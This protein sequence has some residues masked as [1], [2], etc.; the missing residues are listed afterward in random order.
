MPSFSE[1]LR[2]WFGYSRRERRSTFILLILIVAVAGV[3][4]VLPEHEII[5]EELTVETNTGTT[6]SMPFGENVTYTSFRQGQQVV[7]ARKPTELINLNTSDS[8]SLEALPGIGPVLSVRIIKYRNLLGGYA[9]VSQLKEVYGLSEETFNLISGRVIADSASVRKI[10]I[11]YSDFKELIRFPYFEREEVNAILKYL[12]LR[13]RING[14]GDM[15]ENKLI[16]S[17]KAAKLRPYI[18]FGD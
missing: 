13:G 6:D 4:F 12:E 3:R 8:A 5:V 14:V 16:T 17:D 1:P 2:N 11:N 18:E 15:V 10:K 7:K 9:S